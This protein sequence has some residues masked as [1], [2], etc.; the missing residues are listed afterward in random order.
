MAKPPDC[1]ATVVIA[2]HHAC[3]SCMFKLPHS[4]EHRREAVP[5]ERLANAPSDRCYDE[6]AP[7]LIFDV[8]GTGVTVQV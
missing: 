3:D 1:G 8:S 6:V 5:V 7:T 2:A 4:T